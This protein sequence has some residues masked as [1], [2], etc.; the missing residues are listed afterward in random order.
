[1]NAM[2]I[3]VPCVDTLTKNLRE[4]MRFVLESAL[5]SSQE[6]RVR[7]LNDEYASHQFI[8]GSFS[9]DQCTLIFK[10]EVSESRTEVLVHR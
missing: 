7:A 10:G 5:Y 6:E 1:M 9:L 2:N 3:V 4:R 8:K